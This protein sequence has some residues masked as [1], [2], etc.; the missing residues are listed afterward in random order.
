M[1]SQQQTTNDACDWIV[2]NFSLQNCYFTKFDD[3]EK[4]SVDIF[5]EWFVFVSLYFFL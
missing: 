4:K 5:V 3:N 1:K 2:F